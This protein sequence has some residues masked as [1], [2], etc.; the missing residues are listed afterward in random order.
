MNLTS[1]QRDMKT[2]YHHNLYCSITV[3]HI[4]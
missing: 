1:Q 2:S 4:G 3:Q